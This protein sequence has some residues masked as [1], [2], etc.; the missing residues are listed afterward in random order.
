[1]WGDYTMWGNSGTG[2]EMSVTGAASLIDE[3]S[4][5]I[6]GEN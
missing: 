4:I 3:I 1:M 6:Y 5:A 2:S